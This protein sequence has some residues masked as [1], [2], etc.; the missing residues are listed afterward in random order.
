MDLGPKFPLGRLLI[1]PNA[2][3]QVPAED[4]HKALQRH[5]RGDWGDVA[6]ARAHGI[7]LVVIGEDRSPIFQARDGIVMLPIR[8]VTSGYDVLF[9]Q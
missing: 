9:P 1:T 6:Y 5:A 3:R 2:A 7:A 4:V 8:P